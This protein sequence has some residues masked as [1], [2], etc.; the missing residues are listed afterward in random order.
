M[1]GSV[2][3]KRL[4]RV[5]YT[6]YDDSVNEKVIRALREKFGVE[7]VYHK[8]IVLPEFRYL[9]VLLDKPGL[10]EEIKRVVSSLIASERVKVD[11]IDTTR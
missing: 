7:V 8:S 6:V 2:A 5:Y 9:E 4:Y 3:G 11:W 1:A 10:E